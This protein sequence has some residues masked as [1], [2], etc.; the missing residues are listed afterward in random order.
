MWNHAFMATRVPRSRQKAADADAPPFDFTEAEKDRAAEVTDLIAPLVAV[1][2]QA[3][4]P[5]TEVVLH[6]LTRMP[7]T[8]AAIGGS[9]TGREV[10][11]PP[12]DLGLRDFSTGTGEHKVGYRT[13]TADGLV[14]RSSSIFFHAKSGRPVACL[15]INQDVDDLERARKV[16][17]AL[18]GVPEPDRD[19]VPAPGETF[20][21]SVDVLAE[22]IMRNAIDAVGVPVNLMKKSH[23]VQVVREL[24]ENG[25]FTIREAV[26][27]AAK[28]LH[29]SRYTVYNYL[30]EMGEGPAAEASYEA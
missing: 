16:L 6:D 23:K 3:L 25:F 22:G 11:G 28:R 12:T 8:I 2:A 18:T 27:I 14:M 21:V 29:V 4:Q 17:A 9:I 15:C 10:G 20:P 7:N 13:E 5:R 30:N 26:D 19:S 1:L 24:N